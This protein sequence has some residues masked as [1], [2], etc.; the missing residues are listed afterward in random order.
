ME[1]NLYI[2]QASETT[3]LSAPNIRYYEKE[4]LIKNLA[5]NEVGERIFTDAEIDWILFLKKLR[6]MDVP[7]AKM[8]EYANLREQGN[9]TAT[10]RKKILEEH[11]KIMFEKIVLIN[12]QIKLLDD[13]I[14]YYETL[15][16]NENGVVK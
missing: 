11:R 5:R 13:K 10:A 8:R 16:N 3:G 14:I 9:P 7:I 4:G 1:K 12:E 2:K 6:D 15:E